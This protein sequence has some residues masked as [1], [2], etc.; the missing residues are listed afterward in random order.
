[1]AVGKRRTREGKIQLIALTRRRC[2]VKKKTE[3][4]GAASGCR[5]R[6]RGG[7]GGKGLRWDEKVKKTFGSIPFPE[8]IP[9][10]EGRGGRET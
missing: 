5:G 9:V 3:N 6:G 2:G 8:V 4:G 7:T 10:P 1:V